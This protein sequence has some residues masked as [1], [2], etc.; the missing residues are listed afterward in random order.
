MG[1]KTVVIRSDADSPGR[2]RESRFIA[3]T[4]PFWA[5]SWLSVDIVLRH[6]KH[7]S[8]NHHIPRC[9]HTTVMQHVFLPLIQL[10]LFP[11]VLFYLAEITGLRHDFTKATK[12]SFYKVFPICNRR[13]LGRLQFPISSVQWCLWE[14]QYHHISLLLHF[15]N[16]KPW[17][18]CILPC[19]CMPEVKKEQGSNG[20]SDME[21]S[22]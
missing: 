14:R 9:E 18:D 19:L 16:S 15:S 1:W 8:T 2:W 3:R 10:C 12:P 5:V 21:V 7:N 22:C 4:R 20:K 17:C 13:L 11:I 6:N